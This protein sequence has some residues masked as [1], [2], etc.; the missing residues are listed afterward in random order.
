[1]GTVRFSENVIHNAQKIVNDCMGAEDSFCKSRC[2][3]ST[4]VKKYIHCISEQKYKEAVEVIRETLFLPDTLGRIC[5][6][7]C[8]GE[9]RRGREFG[10]PISI[11]ALKRFAAEQADDESLWDIRVGADTGKKVAVIGS[12]PAGAQ[13]AIDLRKAGHDVTIYERSQKAGGMLQT[14]IPAYRLP[15]KVIDQEYTYLDRL[16]IRFQLGTDIGTD[17]SFESLQKENDAVLIAVGAQQ[18]SIV[19]VPG[20]DA[21]GVFSALDFLREI[22]RSGSFE[23]AGKRIMIIGGGDVAMD[24]A[25][26]AVRLGAEEVMQ[27]SL[28]SEDILPASQEE[29]EEALEE[30]VQCHFGWGPDAVLTEGGKVAGIRI[31]KVVS[32]YDEQGRFA[33]EYGEEIK[34]IGTDTV[35][36]ATGQ[37]VED[38]TGGILRQGP[39]GRYQ[40]DEETLGTALENV[41]VAGDAAGGKIVVEAMALGRKAAISINR[42]LSGQDLRENREF[43]KE[44]VYKTQLDVPLPNGTEDIQRI[45][46]N[47]RAAAERIQDFEPIDLGFS[48]EEAVREALRCLQCECRLCI[49]ECV[50]LEQYGKC[51][52]EICGS[53]LQGEN[54]DMELAYSCNDCDSCTVVCPRELPVREIFMETRKDFVLANGKEP[55]LQGHRAVKIHQE[56][57][58]SSM[59]TTKICGGGRDE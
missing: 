1:M 50:M 34:D 17:I 52:K 7:P 54:L 55:P 40:V 48:E 4:D 35:I 49:K 56:L 42:Y 36:M 2:P 21:D 19:P 28:E 47:K 39:G 51:P 11:A 12:G 13:A 41:F 38:V 20:S 43:K 8:E 25:R 9:C 16:G 22:S 18:G 14:G 6:H 27:C 5:A 37:R 45:H 33:P 31:R 44:G 58:F 30:G 24:C 46:K 23:K 26:S 59:Y 57:G 3:M 53:L 29:K 15:R 10:Q 32:V